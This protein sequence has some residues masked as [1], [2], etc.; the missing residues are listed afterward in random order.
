[1]DKLK[2][3]LIIILFQLQ[4]YSK[5]FEA[6]QEKYQTPVYLSFTHVY[7]SP[8]KRGEQTVQDAQQ[9]LAELAGKDASTQNIKEIGDSTFS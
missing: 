9:T 6:H 5:H 8:D 3:S 4:K 7:F 1:M 2:K